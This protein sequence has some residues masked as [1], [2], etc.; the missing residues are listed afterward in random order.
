[1]NNFIPDAELLVRADLLR[2][3][4][5]Q[6]LETKGLLACFVDCV[7][8]EVVGS[9]T[10]NLMTK[11]DI[12]ISCCF[13]P[14]EPGRLIRI[15]EKITQ[16]LPVGRMT[17]INPSITPW[18]EYR[19]GYFCGLNIQETPDVQW[20]VDIWAYNKTDF[21]VA[22]KNHRTLAEKLR[23][24]DR[25]MILRLKSSCTVQSYLV[26]AAVLEHGVKTCEELEKHL[27]NDSG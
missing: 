27:R 9:V 5:E 3:E 26:Y 17:F 10:T 1:M 20:N 22:L 4:A 24:V 15:G 2:R 6:L 19:I 18:H 12:D 21:G 8:V 7:A 13:D 14:F 16:C 25:L 23:K 11:R